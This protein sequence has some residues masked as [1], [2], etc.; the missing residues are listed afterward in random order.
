[1][2]V[3]TVKK[4]IN[5]NGFVVFA[6]CCIRN[7]KINCVVEQKNGI[8][9]FYFSIFFIDFYMIFDISLLEFSQFHP[10]KY[11]SGNSAI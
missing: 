7:K 5:E 8:E 10:K 2:H 11:R 9:N 4:F 6:Y 3:E 1:M